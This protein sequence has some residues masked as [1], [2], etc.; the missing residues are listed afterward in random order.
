M[1]RRAGS[2]RAVA[3]RDA[4]KGIVEGFGGN[5]PVIIRPNP[6]TKHERIVD[7]LNAAAAAGITKLSFS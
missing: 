4:L 6:Q 1:Q 2:A 5:N 7:V 3:L